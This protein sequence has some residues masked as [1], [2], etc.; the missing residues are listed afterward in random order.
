MLNFLLDPF[1]KLKKKNHTTL[2]VLYT[3]ALICESN[4]LHKHDTSFQKIIAS[5][6]IPNIK[7]RP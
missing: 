2:L 6:Q 7:L 4:H 5:L 3:H 1:K